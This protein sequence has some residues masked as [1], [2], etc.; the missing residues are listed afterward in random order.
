MLGVENALV[1]S[2]EREV[3]ENALLG[4]NI[5]STHLEISGDLALS[6]KADMHAFALGE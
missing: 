2:V 5:L 1:L 4:D 3:L 6:L